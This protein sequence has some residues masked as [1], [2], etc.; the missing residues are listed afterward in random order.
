MN[1][2][3]WKYV[4]L[5]AAICFAAVMAYGLLING[6][7]LPIESQA[8]E[9][10]PVTTLLQEESTVRIPYLPVNQ[11]A[12][13]PVASPSLPPS[14]KSRAATTAPTP[15]GTP[16]RPIYFQPPAPTEKHTETKGCHCTE[17]GECTCGNNCQCKS[18]SSLE[19]QL[20]AANEN[21]RRYRAWKMR[22]RAWLEARGYRLRDEGENF[23]SGA[24]NDGLYGEGKPKQGAYG[25]TIIRY[26]TL[27]LK[28]DCHNCQRKSY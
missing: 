15:D 4:P 18:S 12:T 26:N 25:K 3:N 8:I 19:Q 6:Y 27:P 2:S 24:V 13:Q 21:L 1:D 5:S 7:R 17:G 11:V 16:V 28:R 14:A 10:M 23:G 20:Q 22:M 9:V